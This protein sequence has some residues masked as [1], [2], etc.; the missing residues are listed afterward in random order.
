MRTSLDAGCCFKPGWNR[1]T[2]T[3]KHFAI[4]ATATLSY[5][6]S[7]SS[8]ITLWEAHSNVLADA[9]KINLQHVCVSNM[10][11][12]GLSAPLQ[13]WRQ[14]RQRSSWELSVVLKGVV[15]QA[16]NSCGAS[17]RNFAFARRAAVHFRRNQMFFSNLTTRCK[18]L[19]LAPSR[20][21]QR[22][23]CAATNG[24]PALPKQPPALRAVSVS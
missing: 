7:A 16:C 24:L 4:C 2:Q 3:G 18:R 11:S 8:A 12:C 14:T 9:L 21:L 17:L 23:M 5:I 22:R 13:H 6:H 15:T 19:R 10:L 20:T 1:C